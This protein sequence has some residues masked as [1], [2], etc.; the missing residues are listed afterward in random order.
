[1]TGLELRRLVAGLLIGTAMTLTPVAA[2]AE[3]CDPT[4]MSPVPDCEPQPQAPVHYDSWQTHGWDYYCTGDHP[5]FWGLSSDY[6]S[7]FTWDSTC[8]SVAENWF[9]EGPPN[10]FAATITNW[11]INPDGQQITVTLGCS[12][13]PP[14]GYLPQCTTVGGA[15]QDPGCGQSN[16]RTFCNGTSPP[17][18]FLTYSETCPNKTTY[19]C[20]A[21]N[22]F[23]WCQQCQ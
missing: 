1:M 17:V 10:K 9:G 15:V 19:E 7:N 5:Y 3:P 21:D 4:I 14:P 8:F 23:A 6:L 20:T 18:C 11:C 12:K 22:G 2:R 13:D 16:V